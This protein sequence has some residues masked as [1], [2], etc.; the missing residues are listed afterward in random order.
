[1][2]DGVVDS[3]QARPSKGASSQSSSDV[4]PTSLSKT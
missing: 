3:R 1:M 4:T 2:L